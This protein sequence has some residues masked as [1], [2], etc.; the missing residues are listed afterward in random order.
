MS[1]GAEALFRSGPRNCNQRNNNEQHGVEIGPE[2]SI[3]CFPLHMQKDAF[4]SHSGLFRGLFC[5]VFCLLMFL[6]V[7]PKAI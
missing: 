6:F 2:W 4:T 7:L 5:F 1:I 3:I